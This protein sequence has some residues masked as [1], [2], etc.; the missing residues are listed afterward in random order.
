VTKP[1]ILN[2]TLQ[3]SESNRCSIGVP[4]PAGPV[5]PVGPVGPSS[6]SEDKIRLWDESVKC[7]FLRFRDPPSTI[8]DEV[9]SK[10]FNVKIYSDV[11]KKYLEK[12]RR[13]FSDFRNK[14][15]QNVLEGVDEYKKIRR[16]RG[17]MHGNLSMREVREYIDDDITEKLLNRQLAGVNVQELKKN[18]GFEV[19]VEFTR[20]TF[21][22]SWGGKNLD[23]VKALDSITKDLIIPSRSGSNIMNLF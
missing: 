1:E 16:E 8:L 5:D 10:I 7:L 2:L 9:I 3:M 17:V 4:G 14:F 21:R 23:A 18:G 13:T 20:E 22:V 12:T 11:A 6:T 15:N 19:L